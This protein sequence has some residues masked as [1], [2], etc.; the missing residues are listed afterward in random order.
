[1]QKSYLIFDGKKINFSYKDY[2]H[3]SF[4]GEDKPHFSPKLYFLCV[5]KK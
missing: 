2:V 4:V 5:A 3:I 1:M